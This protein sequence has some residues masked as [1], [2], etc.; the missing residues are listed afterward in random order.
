[1]KRQ[2]TGFHDRECQPPPDHELQSPFAPGLRPGANSTCLQWLGAV[3]AWL[4][5]SPAFFNSNQVILEMA[6][7]KIGPEEYR[8]LLNDLALRHI[9]VMAVGTLSRTL[10]GPELPPRVTGGR[11]AG[12]LALTEDDATPAAG[13]RRRQSRP[14]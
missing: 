13:S 2:R 8:E 6:G 12:A 7:L 14:R 5:R 9:C 4:A 11:P 1:M 10:V 3:D